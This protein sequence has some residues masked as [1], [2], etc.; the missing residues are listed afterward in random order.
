[1]RLP[2][3][4]D[5]GRKAGVCRACPVPKPQKEKEEDKP[6]QDSGSTTTAGL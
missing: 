6:L 1:M 4:T 2:L 3:V 5:F